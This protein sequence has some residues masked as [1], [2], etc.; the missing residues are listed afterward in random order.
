MKNP[1]SV[2][3]K[4]CHSCEFYPCFQ[5]K[6]YDLGSNFPPGK[7]AKLHHLSFIG[8]LQDFPGDD[9]IMLVYMVGTLGNTYPERVY[10]EL[11]T[12][13]TKEFMIENPAGDHWMFLL[14]NLYPSL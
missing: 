4:T 3:K 10:K 11:P 6:V 12:Q 2:V 1:L 8:G 9:I 14:F 5:L 13:K 7:S